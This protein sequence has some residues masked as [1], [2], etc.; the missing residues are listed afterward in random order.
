MERTAQSVAFVA[1]IGTLLKPITKRE[2]QQGGPVPGN[3]YSHS[4]QQHQ[5]QTASLPASPHT[6]WAGRT[7]AVLSSV[8]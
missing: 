7:A 4:D 3:L 2:Y 8:N 1:D 6:G 5:W